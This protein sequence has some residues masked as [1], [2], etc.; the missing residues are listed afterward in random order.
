MG[1]PRG[2]PHQLRRA[3]L[4]AALIVLLSQPGTTAGAPPSLAGMPL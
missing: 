2:W 4:V 1:R 3:L